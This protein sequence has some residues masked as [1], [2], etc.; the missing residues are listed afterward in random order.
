MFHYGS[1]TVLSIDQRTK[2]AHSMYRR[3]F[4]LS[5]LYHAFKLCSNFFK[6]KLGNFLYFLRVIIDCVVSVNLLLKNNAMH[7]RFSKPSRNSCSSL[8][9]IKSL[10]QFGHCLDIG[11]M[12]SSIKVSEVTWSSHGMFWHWN[13]ERFVPQITLT[14]SEMRALH[15]ITHTALREF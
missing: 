13:C 6:K 3:L 10:F 5:I 14:D 8:T 4:E 2:L 7:T 11:D 9:F 1:R 12:T 15:H